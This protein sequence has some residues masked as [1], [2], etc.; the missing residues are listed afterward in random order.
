MFT[1]H[2]SQITTAGTQPNNP[3]SSVFVM[4]PENVQFALKS[5]TQG[6]ENLSSQYRCFLTETPQ[7]E[8]S[9]VLREKTVI[10]VNYCS[11]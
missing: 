8:F 9:T 5:F 11:S 4:V 3:V 10:L 1:L 6:M 7:K 2:A